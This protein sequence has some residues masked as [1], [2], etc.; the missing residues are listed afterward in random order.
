[1]KVPEGKNIILTFVSEKVGDA[2]NRWAVNV[3]LH[4]GACSGDFL[5]VQAEDGEGQ[6]IDVATFEFAGRTIPI[7]SGI[8]RLLYDDFVAGKHE[9]GIWMRRPGADAIPGLLTFA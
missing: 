4:G 8:G 3:T 5:A 9:R 1:M 2:K 6:P 7:R